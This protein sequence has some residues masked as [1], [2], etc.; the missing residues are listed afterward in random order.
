MTHYMAHKVGVRVSKRYQM[1]GKLDTID[2]RFRFRFSDEI[3]ALLSVVH[4][5]LAECVTSL[6]AYF[7]FRPKVKLPLSVDL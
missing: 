6:S 7:R 5:V 4:T 2:F 1:L 3:P